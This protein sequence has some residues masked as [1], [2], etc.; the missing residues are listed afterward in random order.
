[1]LQRIKEI[2]SQL[3]EIDSLLKSLPEGNFTC[4]KNGEYSK[5]YRDSIY[6]PKSEEKL[7][8]QLA[9]RK[10]LTTLYNELE[11]ELKI[12]QGYVK[13]ISQNNKS[14]KMLSESNEMRR[15]TST[16]YTPINQ[17]LAE[18]MAAPYDK[19]P[20]YQEGLIHKSISGNY[21][22]SKSE[23]LID[24][25]LFKARIPYRYECQLIIGKNIFF[26]DFTLRHPLT[27]EIYYWEHFGQMD[28]PEY[29]KK[30]CFKI[31]EYSS[32]GI[33][34]SVNLIITYET[35]D[36][37]LTSAVVNKIITHYFL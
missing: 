16:F 28:N 34:P 19:N 1:M 3:A 27:G 9:F 22:R 18:W 8:Q 17:K 2:E 36:N 31:Q 12:S 26:P 24:M 37:P 33:I 14:Q 10:Y 4:T 20:S 35:K 13:K 5:W 21:L 29:C 23:V 32:N 7:A 15:L 6:L 30:A 11:Y 25:L